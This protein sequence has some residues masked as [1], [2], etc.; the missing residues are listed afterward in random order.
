MKSLRIII[1]MIE[2]PLPFG[3]ASARWLYVLLKGLIERGHQVTA[4]ASCSNPSDIDQ[5]QKLFANCDLRCF[6]HP[7]RRGL[8]VKLETLRQPYSY[9]FSP[10]LKQQ[11]NQ[12]LTK[13]FDILHLEQVWAGWLGLKYKHKAFVN[14]HFLHSIDRGLPQPQ[15]WLAA[16]AESRI[17]KAY[18]HLITLS[19]R[20]AQAIHK[21]APKSHIDILPLGIDL[22]LYP[23]IESKPISDQ[24]TVGLI[25]S[26]SWTPTFAA[27]ERLI[28]KLWQPIKQQFP[29]AKL[30]MVGRSAKSALA[31]FEDIPDLEIH[32]NV[33][34]AM[35]YFHQ[36]D[37]MVYAPLVGSG[38]KVKVMESF[39]LGIPVVTAP[40]G[41]EGLP[42]LDQV[43]CG[44]CLEDDDLIKRTIE[45][46]SNPHIA[47]QY[48]QAARQMLEV[49]CSPEPV[50][51]KLE[52]IYQ[53]LLIYK[54][55][56]EK[57]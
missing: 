54:E 7:E 8:G 33:A 16:Q 43:H 27:A 53:R 3:D 20:L 29:N 17:L 47:K 46:L 40:D 45:I 15:L 41:V 21:I 4:F 49:T 38:M 30:L 23:F 2:A 22:S 44:V 19:D 35:P 37:V 9:V 56:K 6:L 39:A 52:Q 51:D 48:R 18:P 25:G 10:E 34:D 57:C 26:F 14:V 36:L 31:K 24:L 13:P 5:A 50:L 12:E 55:D 42:A 11:L 32:E 1:V 28:T